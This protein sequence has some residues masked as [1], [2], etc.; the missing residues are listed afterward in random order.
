MRRN[1]G[2]AGGG[3]TSFGRADAADSGF[4]DGHSSAAIPDANDFSATP[5]ERL[6]NRSQRRQLDPFAC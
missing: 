6:F 3:T 4:A 1:A 5:G 2:T